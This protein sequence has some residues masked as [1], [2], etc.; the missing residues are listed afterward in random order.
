MRANVSKYELV[1]PSWYSWL[2]YDDDTPREREGSLGSGA[3]FHPQGF[4]LTNAPF[5]GLL[6][7]LT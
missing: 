6:P 7:L 4:V 3:I 1:T 5:S 2:A